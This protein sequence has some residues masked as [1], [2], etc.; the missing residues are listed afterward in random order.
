[1]PQQTFDHCALRYLEQWFT[2]DER[3]CRVIGDQSLPRAERVAA[4]KEAMT[5]Y[6]IARCLRTRREPKDIEER[7]GPLLD[8]LDAIDSAKYRRDPVKSIS[9]FHAIVQSHY[10]KNHGV[11]SMVSKLLWLKLKSP[12]IIYDGNAK[13]ALGH[14]RKDIAVFNDMW[15]AAYDTKAINAA[16]KK[17]PAVESYVARNN[18]KPVSVTATNIKAVI[19]KPW[20]KERVFD[21]YLWNM[22]TPPP[23]AKG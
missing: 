15:K 21:I 5:F 6:K 3:F 14:K 10:E 8:K 23:K 18:H 12:F 4:L 17:L 13:R 9:D 1:M 11:L 7:Y 22:G 16:C 2:K 20:F 19:N